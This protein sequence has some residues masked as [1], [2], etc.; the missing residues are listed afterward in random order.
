MELNKER[1]TNKREILKK[2][3]YKTINIQK[4]QLELKYFLKNTIRIILIQNN[5]KDKL[6]F[7][8]YI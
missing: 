5:S 2:S 7:F 1:T 3:R 8:N 6:F 4:P